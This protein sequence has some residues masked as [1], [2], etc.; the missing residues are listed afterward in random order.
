MVLGRGPFS[1]YKSWTRSDYWHDP[2]SFL[3]S[4]V[5]L[6]LSP[7]AELAY[8]CPA[9]RRRI[10]PRLSG[11]VSRYNPLALRATFGLPVSAATRWSIAS[12]ASRL[13]AEREPELLGRGKHIGAKLGIPTAVAYYVVPIKAAKAGESSTGRKRRGAL[14]IPVP[15]FEDTKKPLCFGGCRGAA[16]CINT[17]ARQPCAPFP[18][19]KMFHY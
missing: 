2:F 12:R 8:H 9:L 17:V 4:R 11:H 3:L 10:N 7:L 6:Q 19:A 15:L 13:T 14:F 5:P 16:L 18:G 1:A